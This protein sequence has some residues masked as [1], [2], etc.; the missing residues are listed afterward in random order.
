MS[1]LKPAH[2]FLNDPS[3]VEQLMSILDKYAASRDPET[4]DVL[5]KYESVCAKLQS[6]EM[7]YKAQTQLTAERGENITRLE[8]KLFAAQKAEHK[9]VFVQQQLDKTERECKQLRDERNSV[10]IKAREKVHQEHDT[11]LQRLRDRH[12][13]EMAVQKNHFEY[14]E[15]KYK[16]VKEE[17]DALALVNENS[18][19]KGSAYEQVQLHNIQNTLGVH[20]EDMSKTAKSMDLRV[21]FKGFHIYVDTKNYKR[22]T[23]TDQI[24]KL[25]ADRAHLLQVDEFAKGFIMMST[26]CVANTNTLEWVSDNLYR[27]SPQ[28]YIV[29]QNNFQALILG[30]IYCAWAAEKGAD[31]EVFLAAE[32]RDNTPSFNTIIRRTI[33]LLENSQT[34]VKNMHNLIKT[35][36]KE[37]KADGAALF[38]AVGSS[39][40]L[41]LETEK[42]YKA[43]GH[44]R[45]RRP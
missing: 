30:F 17:R 28:T 37:H 26:S 5:R 45:R 35:H 36:E 31:L 13:G 40:I 6:Y 14:L 25:E 27:H 41:G 42:L 21:E 3:V 43:I 10:M 15:S 16:K 39:D 12:L 9:L 38:E 2:S 18:S 29:T 11:A 8:K 33:P 20:V 34:F 23:N 32:Q 7:R 1:T 19:K 44:K 4:A 22:S 24:R